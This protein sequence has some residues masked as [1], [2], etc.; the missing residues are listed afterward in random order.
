MTHGFDD[1]GAKFD[2][3]GNLKDW[4]AP[5]DMKKFQAATRCIA[6]Q[7]SRYTVPGGLHVQGDLV[8]GEAAADLGGLILAWRALHALPAAA[9]A[10]GA[11][12]QDFS[13]DQRFFLAFAH[14]WAGQMRP[15]Q[16][17]EL[18]TTD[19]H[20]PAEFRTNGTLANDAEF[21]AAFG[22]PVPSPSPKG[23]RCVI[24]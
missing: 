18:V 12:K 19:P 1:Q 7:F 4:W 22:I 14:S 3:H 24:W 10:S 21:Y 6:E 2:G 8:T 11:G 17:Q 15:E 13:A 20:P 9:D 23:E 5:D 16:A